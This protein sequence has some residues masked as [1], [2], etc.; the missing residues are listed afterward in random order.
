MAGYIRS[1]RI[2]IAVLV[3]ALQCVGAADGFIGLQQ[4]RLVDRSTG[5]PFTPLGFAY[6]T[7]NPPVFATQTYA[8][9]ADD[10]AQMKAA[11]ATSLR[12]EMTWGQLEVADGVYDWSKP[13][14][15]LSAADRLGL[16]VF[17]L[18]GYQYPPDW[19]SRDHGEA[20]A[21]HRDPQTG[22]YGQSTILNYRSAYARD[23]YARHLA[24]VAGRYK[25]RTSVAAWIIGNEFAIYDLWEAPSVNPRKRLVGH[26][27]VSR[28]SWTSHLQS[29]FPTIADLNAAWNTA[30]ADF[31]SVPIPWQF[32]YG[33]T[34]TGGAL[35]QDPGTDEAIRQAGWWDWTQW[36]KAAIA[37]FLA[38]GCAAIRSAD[39]NHLITY[40]TVGG[41]FSLYN[42]DNSCEDARAIVGACTAAD[43]TGVGLDFWTVNNYPQD[44]EL[45]SIGFGLAKY[46][47]AI[48]LP[49]L[50]TETGVSSN[51]GILTSLAP[52]QAAVLPSL[53]W[54]TL[55]A[56]ALGVHIFHWNDR[57]G[58]YASGYPLDR[59][60]GFG[61]IAQDR[62][63]SAKPAYTAVSDAFRA[64]PQSG[65][66][67]VLA[68]TSPAP[69]D[70][71]LYWGDDGDVDFNRINY[72]CS[73]L[74][75]MLSAQGWTVR[76]ISGGDLDAANPTD[77]QRLHGAKAILLPG[78][79]TLASGRLAKLQALATAG[80]V[81]VALAGAPGLRNERFTPVPSAV[82]INDALFGVDAVAASW[83]W[84]TG[85]ARYAGLGFI[86][87]YWR[88]AGDA[89]YGNGMRVSAVINALGFSTTDPAISVMPW[90]IGQGYAVTSGTTVLTAD[91]GAGAR[92]LLITRTGSATAAL[93]TSAIPWQSVE[94]TWEP[95]GLRNRILQTAI[96]VH[97]GVSSSL[98]MAGVEQ[99][100]RAWWPTSDGGA[101]IV[102]LNQTASAKTGTLT[103]PA[104]YAGRAVRDLV[105]GRILSDANPGSI[106]LDGLLAGDA[107]VVLRIL[108]AAMP[109]PSHVRVVAA[110]SRMYGGGDAAA[111]VVDADPRGQP[112]TVTVRLIDQSGVVRSQASGPATAAGQ[113]AFS[114]PVPAADLGDPR[115]RSGPV[116]IAAE[117]TPVGGGGSATTA[118]P[119]DLRWAVRPLAMPANGPGTVTIP[120]LWQ[121]LPGYLR[122]PADPPTQVLSGEIG[123]TLSRLD[124]W[125]VEGDDTTQHYDMVAEALDGGGAVIASGS[126]TTS[127]ATGNGAIAID[128]PSAASSWRL[129]AVGGDGVT[130]GTWLSSATASPDPTGNTAPSLSPTAAAG[131][132]PLIWW[133][134]DAGLADDGLPH[135]VVATSWQV[136][137]G[138][139][140]V[141]IDD[142][143][144]PTTTARLTKAG[145]YVLRVR[146]DDGAAVTVRDLPVHV[147]EGLDSTSSLVARWTDGSGID[148]S[149]H[150]HNLTTVTG[151]SEILLPANTTA[152]TAD[153]GE[154]H[155]DEGLSVAAWVRLTSD[156]GGDRVL[157]SKKVSWDAVG[158]WT[159][160]YDRWNRRLKLLGGGTGPF[161]EATADINTSWRHVAATVQGTAVR[162]Y[163][164]GVDITDPKQHE[165]AYLAGS[166]TPVRLGAFVTTPPSGFL[167]GSLGD[168]R[169]YGRSLSASEV[170]ALAAS[171]R[172]P[173]PPA[174]GGGST[175][176]AGG[177]GGCGGGMTAGLVLLVVVL[178][179][180][181]R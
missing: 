132:G 6:Q 69:V 102:L 22:A 96:G 73:A 141:L 47:H 89:T 177:G 49:I 144:L 175:G 55:A 90:A 23:R 38:A 100:Q 162:I 142:P 173:D 59:E 140:E 164:D 80:T 145:D 65:L 153:A 139:G 71:A 61:V 150:G 99:V 123:T 16:R 106:S 5:R 39:P 172:P 83:F 122:D 93:V 171:N 30:H 36:Q 129:R 151:S 101:L 95:W 56:G 43:P 174:S 76:V 91:A 2:L 85:G 124:L 52:R 147:I 42:C 113:L 34:Q 27:P 28:A 163:L 135:G 130:R 35:V 125:P 72:D 133:R 75:G 157:V 107:T 45:R 64:I 119:V 24:A 66:P 136:V 178:R 13:D 26:D 77:P 37:D 46:V 78:N 148:R 82:A 120:V 118:V 138:P 166:A 180:R 137:S 160:L 20:M 53:L 98:P 9:I 97:G 156:A 108:P 14:F 131:S 15:L 3:L 41:L 103:M 58:F 155:G 10:L 158:G 154:L 32:P 181:R 48:G 4:G 81:V 87:D 50:V 146:A 117:L 170:A 12:V 134:L 92:P 29:V 63:V 128:L 33:T 57:E 31:A 143:S 51:D 104:G 68:L 44:G 1:V 86:D 70:V 176:G 110:P 111:V 94:N 126:L 84:R 116:T 25:D 67:E 11:G 7:W 152:Q 74:W 54:E 8:Q 167:D 18:I 161:A 105:T 109:A 114:L 169:V 149:G 159:L 79:R 115:W 165:I 179:L 62:R 121:N 168:V 112:S 19:L 60:V 40:A 127:R 21:V 17:I 88:V